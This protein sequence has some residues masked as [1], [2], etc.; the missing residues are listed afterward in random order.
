MDPFLNDIF[1]LSIKIKYRNEL[2]LELDLQITVSQ[3]I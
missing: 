2:N 3:G 1:R